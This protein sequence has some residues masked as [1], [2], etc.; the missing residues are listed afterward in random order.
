MLI[1]HGFTTATD[2]QGRIWSWRPSFGRV[3][4]LG[5][6][7]ELV[8]LYA[9]LYGSRC[10]GVAAYILAGLCD[11]DDATP[12]IGWPLVDGGR[13]PGEMPP[14]EQVLI[15]RHLMRHA[16]VGKAS[17]KATDSGSYSTEIRLDEFVAI[18]RVHLGMSA[19]DAEAMSMTEFQ[20]LFD[21]KY[22]SKTDD[23]G[24]PVSV[25]SRAAY[26]AAMKRSKEREMANG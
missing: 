6:P 10:A 8:S 11:Q 9:E 5:G 26:E 12:L 21:A 23:K 18:A 22:P 4:R 1:E 19:E 15:A 7:T 25:P 3:S 24:R 16:L 14:A 13:H 20:Q 2:S 17:P